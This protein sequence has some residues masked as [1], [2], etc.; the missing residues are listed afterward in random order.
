[1][2]KTRRRY[3][4]FHLHREGPLISVYQLSAA[5]RKNFLSLFGEVSVAD[6]RLFIGKYDTDEGTGILQCNAES[7]DKLI[8]SAALIASIEGTNVSFEP[9]RAS[10]TLKGLMR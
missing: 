6:S 4:L 5:I 2:R 7:L 3:V 1:M 8:A 9:R 10:G